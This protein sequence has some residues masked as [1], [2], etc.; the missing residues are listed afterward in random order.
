MLRFPRATR[1]LGYLFDGTNSY[2]ALVVVPTGTFSPEIVGQAVSLGHIL[3]GSTSEV[4]GPTTIPTVALRFPPRA[5]RLKIALAVAHSLLELFPSPWFPRDWDKN[6]IYFSVRPDGSVNT[7][8]PFL[9][10][11]NDT[12]NAQNHKGR[13]SA[14]ESTLHTSRPH[15]HGD[16]LLSLGI[17]ILEVWFGQSL[18]SQPS[19]EANFGPNGKEKEFTKFNAAATWQRMV[20]DDGGLLL[21]NITHRC[22][23]GNFDLVTLSLEDAKLIKAVYENV[24]MK[25]QCFYRD[26]FVSSWE[27]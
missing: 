11:R 15:D 2:H 22:V 12:S 7:E 3:A 25:L 21:H 1:Q 27:R 17:L 5:A 16:I 10:P 23:Y 13:E 14:A 18:E 26:V 6:D 19:W 24:V 8:M 9:I 4:T 20:G